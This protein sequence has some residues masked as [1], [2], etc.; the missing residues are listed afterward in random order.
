MFKKAAS[1]IQESFGVLGLELVNRTIWHIENIST[2]SS[3][4]HYSWRKHKVQ[5]MQSQSGEGQNH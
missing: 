3:R 5:D 1:N 2:S 4:V